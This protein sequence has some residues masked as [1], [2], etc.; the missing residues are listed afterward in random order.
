MTLAVRSH[1]APTERET[2]AKLR[3]DALVGPE[4]HP[5][6]APMPQTAAA[7]AA[8]A[9]VLVVDDEP[10][11]REVVARYLE[12]DGHTVFEAADGDAGLAW[13]AANRADLVLLDVMLPGT[14]GF[15][16]LRS[17]R[18]QG[19]VPVILLTARTEEVDRIVG[20]EMGA[21]DYVVKPFSARE[22]AARVRTVLRRS[23][24]APA[25]GPT[26]QRIEHGALR[27]DLAAR[28]VEVGGEAV[29]LTAKEFDLLAL[30]TGSPRQVF[31]RRQLLEQ[32][33]DSAP[34]YQDPATVTVHIGRLR[35]KLERDPDHPSS[36]V[37]VWGVGYRFEP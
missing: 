35:Q 17:I 25:A 9:T 1:G 5:Y 14:D 16:I 37:T 29:S 23:A 18:E 26:G 13:L 8:S 27:I 2:I 12:L 20:L 32:V 7:P 34:E 10:M 30:L 11:V 21:D 3:S 36:I 28:T 22:V 6:A 24:P 4:D 19:D 33:W 31:S 15:T